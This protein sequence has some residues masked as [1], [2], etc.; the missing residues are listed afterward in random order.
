[1]FVDG[2]WVRDDA[3]LR[4]PLYHSRDCPFIDVGFR[5]GENGRP[6][7]GYARWTWR[8]RRCTLPRSVHF[9]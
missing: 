9:L 8:P 3:E 1:M 4:Y 2:E 6:D 5:C 7:D